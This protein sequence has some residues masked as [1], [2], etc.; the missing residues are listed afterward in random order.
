MVTIHLPPLRERKEDIPL[1]VTYFIKKYATQQRV[2]VN[3]ISQEALNLL[4][5]YNW[6]GNIRE[7]EN[8]IEHAVTFCTSDV[9]IPKN[10]PRNL[11]EGET[12][13]GIFPIELSTIDSIDLQE[14]LSEA[15]RKLLLWA[16][17]KTNGNQV[18][19]SEI[20]RIPRTTLQN[21]LVKYNITKTNISATEQA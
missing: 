21:K 15:E 9:I 11:T 5:L 12:P 19:M 2:S 16:Y 14:T 13:S 4:M 1:L 8:V 7:L 17:Q 6:H 18:R 10:L 20:L 3:S